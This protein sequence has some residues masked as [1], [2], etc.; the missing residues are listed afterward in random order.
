[1]RG[2]AGEVAGSVRLCMLVVAPEV[3]VPCKVLACTV[4]SVWSPAPEC[5]CGS[6]CSDVLHCCWCAG[7][8]GCHE[9]NADFGDNAPVWKL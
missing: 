6:D 7:L 3:H 9:D 4:S 2:V 1:M 8:C 5:K